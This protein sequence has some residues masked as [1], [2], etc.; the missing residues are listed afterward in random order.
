MFRAMKARADGFPVVGPSARNLG[1]R[2]EGLNRDIPISPDGT[3]LPETGGMSLA[4][5]AALN[6]PKHRLPIS[7]GGDG[8]D[9]V[10]S[11]LSAALPSSLF[12]R[13][14]RYPHALIE[15]AFVCGF[16]QYQENLS[17]TRLF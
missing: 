7:L 9:P 12:V 5:D 2:T 1:V 6:L 10:F 4:L 3:V 8:R 13:M 15:P 11:I 17:S 16:E 14:D